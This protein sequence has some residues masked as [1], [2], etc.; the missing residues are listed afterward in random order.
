MDTKLRTVFIGIFLTIITDCVFSQ[1]VNS[2]GCVSS[3]WRKR[4][5]TCY[6]KHCGANPGTCVSSLGTPVCRRVKN[7]CNVCVKRWFV[8]NQ[9]VEC[10]RTTATRDCPPNVMLRNCPTNLCNSGCPDAQFNGVSCRVNTCGECRPE[11]FVDG[12]WL[13]CPSQPLTPMD[14]MNDLTGLSFFHPEVAGAVMTGNSASSSS[15]TAAGRRQASAGRMRE[16]SVPAIAASVAGSNTFRSAGPGDVSEPSIC[17][18]GVSPR[19][20]PNMCTGMS[21]ENYPEAEC[22]VNNCGSCTAE[23]FVGELR[24][25]CRGQKCRPGVQYWFN[26]DSCAY[27]YC[28][29]HP[30]AQCRMDACGKC[31]STFWLSNKKVSCVAQNIIDPCPNPQ[32]S[33]YVCNYTVCRFDTCPKNSS[34]SCVVDNCGGCRPRYMHKATFEDAKCPGYWNKYNQGASHIATAEEIGRARAERERQL[35]DAQIIIGTQTAGFETSPGRS[36]SPPISGSRQEGQIG[37]IDLSNIG[38]V[39]QIQQPPGNRRENPMDLLSQL[40]NQIRGSTDASDPIQ[41]T[42]LQTRRTSRPD[43]SSGQTQGVRR[44][45]PRTRS[46]A[47]SLPIVNNSPPLSNEPSV[48]NSRG[49]STSFSSPPRRQSEIP[50][51]PLNSPIDTAQR[52]RPVAPVDLLI[53]RTELVP[54]IDHG[55]S[56]SSPIVQGQPNILPSQ[57][58]EPALPNRP[59]RD[60]VQAESVIDSL[61]QNLDKAIRR[62]HPP[63]A[64]RPSS[65]GRSVDPLIQSSMNSPQSSGALREQTSVV[66][67]KQRPLKPLVEKSVSQTPQKSH[68]LVKK[69][70][71]AKKELASTKSRKQLD[72]PKKGKTEKKTEPVKKAPTKSQPKRVTFQSLMFPT[73]L[74]SLFQTLGGGNAVAIPRQMQETSTTKT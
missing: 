56:G 23:F 26:C 20:C 17:P 57:V 41:P 50:S 4:L 70:Q 48:Q 65:S 52:V 28:H 8:G 53:V 62:A 5:K 7:N 59:L 71:G 3:N 51:L 55:V 6:M 40:N 18:R 72:R 22:R 1:T 64:R 15:S 73:E 14:S 44:N 32:D 39:P 11:Y 61:I 63:N 24:V 68:G 49:S 69:R 13:M 67:S 30:T 43:A 58:Q 54:A 16:P 38:S 31:K 47:D 36:S 12:Q 74:F 9:V 10:E 19:N 27:N 21:C 29:N 66:S 34:V 37:S 2:T 35:R 42:L 33:R 60:N 46:S 45:R 25:N